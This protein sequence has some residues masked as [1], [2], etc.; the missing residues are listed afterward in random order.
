LNNDY[1][2]LIIFGKNTSKTT[3]HQINM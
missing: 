3:G 1:R 2:I